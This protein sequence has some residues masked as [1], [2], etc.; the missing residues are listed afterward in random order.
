MVS[1]GPAAGGG[2]EDEDIAA[3]ESMG[4]G[5]GRATCGS[6]TVAGGEIELSAAE[7]MM[8]AE[9]EVEGEV[10]DCNG[11]T[12]SWGVDCEFATS[13]VAASASGLVF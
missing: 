10:D 1:A 9:V 2:V 6:A 12:G 5:S 3:V 4:S 13:D 8:G 11:A 7:S